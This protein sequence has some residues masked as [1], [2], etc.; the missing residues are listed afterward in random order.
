MSGLDN[1]GLAFRIIVAED[2]QGRRRNF[3]VTSCATCGAVIGAS[4]A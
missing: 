4:P 3:A 2:A 1:Q